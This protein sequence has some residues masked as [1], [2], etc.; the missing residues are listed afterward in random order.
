MTFQQFRYVI[1]IA[2]HHSI[3]KAAAA[4]FVTQPSISKAIRDLEQELDI[5]ILNRT[6]KGVVFTKQGRELLTYASMVM[7]QTDA[8][9]HHFNKTKDPEERRFSI[10]SQ[11]FGF[12]AEALV[13]TM[14]DA[15]NERFEL[16]LRE[17]KSQDVIEDVHMGKSAIGLL[18]VNASNKH[19]FERHFRAKSLG[20]TAIATIPQHVFLRD[21]H[22]LATFET[23]TYEQL[24]PYPYLSYQQDDPM[25][26]FA[27]D[28]LRINDLNQLVYV[29]DRGTM[30][31]LL[32]KTDGYNI[33][34]GCIVE[35]FMDQNITSVPLAETTTNDIGFIKRQDLFLTPQLTAFLDHIATALKRSMPH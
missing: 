8:I 33:G 20:F 34:T 5:T 4:L 29:T 27:E 25:L 9:H 16:S 18:S 6:N 26:H 10:S 11:H 19:Y 35:G 32:S 22:P 3:S 7:E 13:Q 1:E 17:G 24:K 14:D 28:H 31:N 30:N 21:E 23:L 12:A 15:K 2:K